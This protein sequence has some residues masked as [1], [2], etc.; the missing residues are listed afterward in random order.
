MSNTTPISF[1]EWISKYK[2]DRNIRGD[3]ARVVINDPSFPKK[4]FSFIEVKDYYR[5]MDSYLATDDVK[6][7]ALSYLWDDYST[8]QNLYRYKTAK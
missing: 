7:I 8:S 1:Y 6:L 2:K 3:M 4:A 5:Q